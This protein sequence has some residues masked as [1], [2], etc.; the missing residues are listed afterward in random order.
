MNKIFYF[1]SL[2]TVMLINNFLFAQKSDTPV[3][4]YWQGGTMNLQFRFNFNSLDEGSGSG[5]FGR[6]VSPGMGFGA[7]SIFSNPSELALIKKPNLFI[8]SRFKIA[9]DAK[10]LLNN[11]IKDATDTFI[12]DTTTFKFDKTSY[13]QNTTINQSDISSGGQIGTIAAAVP[14]FDGLVFGVGLNYPTDILFNLTGSGINTKLS[15]KKQVGD[16][17]IDID[18]LLNTSLNNNFSFR[19]TELSIG[20]GAELFNSEAGKLLMGFSANRYEVSQSINLDE[21]FDGMIVLYQSEEHHFNDPN[22]PN[23][24]R[25]NGETNN[26]F[27][28]A[29]NNAHTTTTGYRFG[30]IYNT[31]GLIPELSDFNLIFSYDYVPQFDLKDENASLESYQPSFLTGKL[32]GDKNDPLGII[33]DSLKITRPNLTVKTNNYFSNESTFK[34]PS[35]LTY[36]LDVK[37][38]DHSLAFNYVKYLNEYSWQFDKYKIG[39]NLTS[40]VKFGASFRMPDELDGWNWAFLPLRLLYLDFDGMLMQLFSDETKYKNSYYR[41]SGGVVFGDAI[42][43]GIADLDQAKSLRSALSS[44]LPN[45]FALSREYNVFEYV[46]IGVLVFGFPDFA[47]KFGV[48][49]QF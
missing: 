27:F 49:V 31:G 48:G 19:M 40:G 2:I 4:S 14:L 22:D 24:D 46:N 36:G 16:N 11:K 38:G 30:F 33:I 18:I 32:I 1:S 41:I 20:A 37:L 13:R 9:L 21:T 45:G 23:I 28:R 42:V 6:V 43:E 29:N 8:N 47:L 17:S 34:F 44:P 3:M 15:T 26:F 12:N 5:S 39:K 25:T 35:S 7:A 10:S